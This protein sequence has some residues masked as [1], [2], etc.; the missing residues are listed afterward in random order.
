MGM[1]LDDRDDDDFNFLRKEEVVPFNYPDLPEAIQL[2]ALQT[3][4]LSHGMEM[5]GSFYR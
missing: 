3:F 1:K 5:V 4:M 2:H